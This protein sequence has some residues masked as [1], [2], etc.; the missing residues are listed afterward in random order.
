MA[1]QFTFKY[2]PKATGLASVGF[3]PTLSWYQIWW[4]SLWHHYYP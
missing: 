2:Q 4:Q 1:K 3:P